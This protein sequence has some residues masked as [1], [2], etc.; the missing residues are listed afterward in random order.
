MQNFNITFCHIISWKF[1]DS[2]LY[3][4]N[5]PLVCVMCFVTQSCLT[6]AI[7]WVMAQ[8]ASLSRVF[9]MQEYC[10][11][12]PCPP[13]GHLLNPGLNPGVPHYRWIPYHL[14]HQDNP[15]ILEWAPYPFSSG[16]SWPGNWTVGSCIAGRFFHQL[17]YQ[18]S[19]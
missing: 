9:S 13:P 18:G 10:S 8:Q 5:F 12:L 3:A 14:S 17:S 19:H 15:R 4:L 11:G 16:T 6:L 2:A 1:T 7:P